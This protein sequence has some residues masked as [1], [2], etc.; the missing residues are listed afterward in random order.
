MG[1]Q[2]I[3]NLH[4]DLLRE[5]ERER[6]EESKNRDLSNRSLKKDRG[7]ES[8]E[9]T[10]GSLERETEGKRG[11]EHNRDLSTYLGISRKRERGEERRARTE[12]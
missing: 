8:K 2:K 1:R 4:R 3:K 12:I 7:T 5:R 6:E 11:G 9:P 10:L